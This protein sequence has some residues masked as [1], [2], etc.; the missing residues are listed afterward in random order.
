MDP[1]AQVLA[2]IERGHGLDQADVQAML[3]QGL[4]EPAEVRR[5]FAAIEP[6]LYRF[7]A[8]NVPAFRSQVEAALKSS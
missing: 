6:G 8:I 3:E 7:P 1:Y 2:K 4:V 5:L